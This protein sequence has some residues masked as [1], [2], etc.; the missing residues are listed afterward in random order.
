[1]L[2]YTPQMQH[3]SCIRT[4]LTPS[5]TPTQTMKK[6][7]KKPGQRVLTKTVPT[8]SFFHFFSPPE[9]PSINEIDEMMFEELQ[10]DLESNYDIGYVDGRM[11]TAA[12]KLYTNML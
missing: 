1:M 8:D 11:C 2:Q 4:L 10:E 3:V 6:Q 9:L 12:G 5:N 7:P